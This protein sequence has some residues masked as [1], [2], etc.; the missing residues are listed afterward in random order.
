MRKDEHIASAVPP[1][2]WPPPS[3]NAI[4]HAALEVDQVHDYLTDKAMALRQAIEMRDEKQIKSYR[5]ALTSAMLRMKEV[6]TRAV[7]S[8]N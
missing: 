6:V 1:E 3:G 5:R 7:Q 2:R 4:R 8:Q